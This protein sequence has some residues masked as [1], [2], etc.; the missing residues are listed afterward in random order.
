MK[1]QKSAVILADKTRNFIHTDIMPASE[2]QEGF[3]N[4]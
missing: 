2:R 3:V 4:F 1:G